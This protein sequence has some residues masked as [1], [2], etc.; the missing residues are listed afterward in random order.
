MSDN[1]TEQVVADYIN[2]Y[3][4][5]EEGDRI[6]A[7]VSGGADSV[8]LLY[9]LY[10]LK[11]KIDFELVAVHVNHMLR[12]AEARRD[13]DFTK[14]LCNYLGTECMV[15]NVDVKALAASGGMS[16]EEAGRMAR[17]LSFE[18]AAKKLNAAEKK[19]TKVALAHHRD[20]N[21]ET[22]L[23]NLVR[24]SSVNGLKGI[25]PVTERNELVLIRPLLCIGRDDINGYLS[26]NELPHVEDSTNAQS[27]FAR[28]KIRLNVIPEL[29][30]INAKAVEHASDAMEDFAKVQEFLDRHVDE[31]MERIVDVRED[32]VAVNIKELSD[33]DDAVKS[34]VVYRS[35][36]IMAGIQK[37]IT[38]THVKDV[39]ALSGKQTGRRVQLPYELDAVRSY[40]NIIIRK[41]AQQEPLRKDYDTSQIT[42]SFVSGVIIDSGELLQHEK[43]FAFADGGRL[44]MRTVDVTEK[45]SSIL[46]ARNL[47]TKAFDYDKISGNLVLSKAQAGDE[48]T[49]SGG[50]K[51]LK[52][53][54]IDEKIPKE[55]REEMLVLK[56]MESVLWVLGYRIG[57][58]YKITGQT[59]KALIVSIAGGGDER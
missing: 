12:G 35:I 9:I 17:Y 28:N 53:Y 59:K 3:K 43:S 21:V 1:S 30:T 19:N 2:E 10:R 5:I 8:C 20:D 49:F 23:L 22:L 33:A 4:M 54:F 38:H 32:S 58:R 26:Y 56:D 14:K 52:K 6:I 41:R 48:I 11:Q 44:E 15:A 55:E 16:V 37:D 51:T 31:A 40:S 7:G 34:R 42:D 50:T 24:G 18:A 46:T 25:M 29:K 47:Y 39:L 57:E 13:K 45:N 36:G 27:D